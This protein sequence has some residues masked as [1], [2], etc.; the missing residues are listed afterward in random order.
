[1]RFPATRTLDPAIEADVR[2][3]VEAALD[4]LPARLRV[5]VTLA[6]IEERPYAEI[7]DALGISIN[8]VKSR[9]FRAVRLLRKSLKKRG[10]CP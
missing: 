2:A 7:A 4:E 8:G 9:V 6:L 1:M 3:K 5:S 10:V